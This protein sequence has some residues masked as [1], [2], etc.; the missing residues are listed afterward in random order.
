[1]RNPENIRTFVTEDH[2]QPTLLLMKTILLFVTL[3]C[4][5][6]LSNEL[7]AQVLSGN[8]TGTDATCNGSCDGT[9]TANASGG[10]PPYTYLWAPGSQT[11]STVS[12]LCSGTYGV[13]ITDNVGAQV[14]LNH[15]INQPNAITFNPSQ[16]NIDCNGNTNGTATANPSGGTGTLTYSWKPIPGSGQGTANASN[17]SAASYTL[18]VTDSKGCIGTQVFNIT[19]PAPLTA[20][21]SH[22]NVSCNGANDGTATTTVSGGTAGYT[23]TWGPG[24]ANTQTATNLYANTYIVTVTDANGC[25]ISNSVQVLQP[26]ALNV[27]T[28]STKTSCVSNTGTAT[29]TTS[30]GSPGYTYTWSPAP[31]GGQGT[32]NA[33]GLGAGTYTITVQD[34]HGCTNSTA[35]FINYIP[36]PSA[37]LTSQVNA[38]C[39]SSCNGSATVNATGGTGTLTYSWSAG[40]GGSSTATGLCAGSYTC[41]ISDANGCITTQTATITQPAVLNPTLSSTNVKCNGGINDGTATA[42]V[43]GGTPA[44]TYSWSPAPP[45]GQGT[46]SASGLGAGSYTLTCTDANGCTSTATVTITQPTILGIVTTTSTSESCSSCCDGTATIS[47]GGGVTPYTYSW[48]STPVQHSQTATAL[49]SGTYTACITDANGCS[50]C[51]TDTVTFHTGIAPAVEV[52]T[53]LLYPNPANTTLHLNFPSGCSPVIHLTILNI[54]GEAVYTEQN[55]IPNPVGRT[56]SIEHLP[57]GIYFLQLSSGDKQHTVRFLKT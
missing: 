54:L 50:I 28:S 4:S 17:L 30:G 44:Y 40:A 8:V 42:I 47:G 9:M 39:N 5:M 51:G 49:C 19:Q 18:T 24:G 46:T 45:A 6:F 20:T 53:F 55:S 3:T 56:I 37:N 21:M 14:H 11:G 41:D 38:T 1:L 22:T 57:N 23:Y 26:S 7:S 16:T 48:N 35:I 10:T 29:A 27:N 33:T 34:A 13:T 32:P 43:A 52:F 25:T 12:G 31:G 15:T 36:G 2:Q